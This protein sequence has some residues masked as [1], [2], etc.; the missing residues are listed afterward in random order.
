MPILGV[1]EEGM[2][3]L[4]DFCGVVDEDSVVVIREETLMKVKFGTVYS[5]YKV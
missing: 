2:F 4:I 5:K 3:V 1:V